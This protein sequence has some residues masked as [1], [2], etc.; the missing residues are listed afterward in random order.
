MS[1]PVRILHLSY[2]EKRGNYGDYVLTHAV[3][4]TFEK[5]CKHSISWKP[6]NIR[7]WADENAKTILED[8]DVILVGGGGLFMAH[9]LSSNEVS[10]WHWKVSNEVLESIQIPIIVFTVG[11]NYFWGQE[12]SEL[13]LSSVE[14]LSQKTI[15]FSLRHKGDIEKLL[16]HFPSDLDTDISFVPCT[17]T[18]INHLWNVPT[19]PG[20]TKKIAINIPF[21]RKVLRYGETPRQKVLPIAKGIEELVDKGYS[22]TVVL[23]APNFD[24]EILDYL[25]ELNIPHTIIDIRRYSVE[26]SFNFYKSFDLVIAGRGHSQMIPFGLGIPVL[27]LHVHNKIKFFLEDINKLD[28]MIDLDDEDK[29]QETLVEKAL[30]MLQHKRKIQ[31][32]IEEAKENLFHIIKNNFDEFNRYCESN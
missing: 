4:K 1:E 20:K 12:P 30:Y 17:T 26:D 5:F 14:L 21:D 8:V 19:N 29:I 7:E 24:V 10:G 28:W 32:E 16:P 3:R 23:H 11:F 9:G 2:S 31:K 22:I 18:I 27:S 15:H 6:M 13:F 25:V